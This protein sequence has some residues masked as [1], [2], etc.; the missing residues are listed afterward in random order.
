MTRRHLFIGFGLSISA[1]LCG[2]AFYRIDWATFRQALS[3]LNPAIF[4]PMLGLAFVGLTLRSWRWR[5]LAG[6]P[7][8]LSTF[9]RAASLGYL[10]N[11][12]YPLRAG[13][14]IRIVVLSRQAEVPLGISASS[15]LA[16]RLLDLVVFATLS[17]VAVATVSRQAS[18][19]FVTAVAIVAMGATAVAVFV[20][21]ANGPVESI[22]RRLHEV[23]PSEWLGSLLKF[24][25]DAVEIR[26]VFRRK[27]AVFALLVLTL[28]IT[29]TDV[30]S[31]YLLLKAFG[32]Q[33]PILAAVTLVSFIA[34]GSA[35]PAAP[36]Y[37]GVYQAA[38]VLALG[39]FGLA[40]SAALAFSVVFHLFVLAFFT[41]AGL[42]T[43]VSGIKFPKAVQDKKRF[44]SE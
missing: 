25:L 2:G 7:G 14:A 31:V 21:L 43:I 33:L 44:G 20:L 32:W 30:L 35:L 39:M 29:A 26:H 13:E 15:S 24:F 4:V 18:E 36:G 17:L 27:E 5:V 9:L 34:L 37:I 19:T 3:E 22:L 11:L 6:S 23:R 1:V 40:S 28:L 38:S 41:L 10:G 16:D 42:I 8:S 12:I